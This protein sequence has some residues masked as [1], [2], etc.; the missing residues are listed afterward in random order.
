M[1]L[2]NVDGLQFA[3]PDGWHVSKYDD[4]VFYRKR[5]SRMLPEI[6]A[7]DLLAMAHDKTAW[8]VE[9]KDYRI[10]QRT[11]PSDLGEEIAR[12]VFSTL[13]ALLP[14]KINANEA[15]EKQMAGIMMRARKL[16]VVLHLEQ[17]AK[18]SK[19]RPRAI[20]PA[21][22]QQKLRQLLKPVDAHPLVVE[23]ARMGMLQWKVSSATKKADL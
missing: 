9:V 16:R 7:L 6:K 23:M 13:A 21:D 3:F 4:W 22:V 5:F 20:D 19:L 8:L 10:N 11:K 2:V 12:K 14:A 18:H 15:D 1:P 17:P